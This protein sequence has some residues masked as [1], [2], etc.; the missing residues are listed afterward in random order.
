MSGRGAEIKL[1]LMEHP[2]CEK[3]AI[4]DDEISDMKDLMAYIVKTDFFEAG[5]EPCHAEELIKKLI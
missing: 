1:W 2:E 3:F 4:V 5:L